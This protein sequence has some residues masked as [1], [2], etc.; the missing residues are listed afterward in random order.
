MLITSRESVFGET[1]DRARA[2]SGRPRGRRVGAVSARANGTR[3]VDPR[4]SCTSRSWRRNSE[5]CRSRWRKPPPTSPKPTPRFS[6]YLK[7]FR[8]RRVTLLERAGGLVPHDGVAVTWAANFE[9]VERASPAAAD[10][11]RI[12]AFLAPDAIPFELFL[13]GGR[14]LATRSQ[15]RFPI[16]TTCWR[17]PSCC[18]H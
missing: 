17:W 14:S 18:E 5:I 8:K 4:A 1:R 15:R 9:A 6:D 16:Q 3:E 11:L 7:A 10:V 13:K 2:R 12:S